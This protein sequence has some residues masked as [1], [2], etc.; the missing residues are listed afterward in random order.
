MV[1]TAYCTRRSLAGYERHGS[2]VTAPGGLLGTGS[3]KVGDSR[4]R[5]ATRDQ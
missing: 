2:S 3:D 4:P 1:W 5:V